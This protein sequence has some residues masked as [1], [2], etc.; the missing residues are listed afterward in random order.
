MS[1][2][3]E[4]GFKAG[5]LTVMAVRPGRT[6]GFIA[7]CRCECGNVIEIGAS[8]IE[9]NGKARGTCKASEHTTDR[10]T[11]HPLYGIWRGMISRCYN[12]GD[13]DHKNY[14][15]K[16]V[17]VCAEWFASPWPFFAYMPERPSMDHTIDRI[18]AAGD[19]K[20]GNVR[21]A[22]A[23]EQANNKRRTNWLPSNGEDVSPTVFWERHGCG[24]VEYKTFLYRLR[25]GWD[26]AAACSPST[27]PRK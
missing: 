7:T 6:R 20:P 16:G 18:D 12:H 27:I 21:W 3:P 13:K 23:T 5:H 1:F 22:T 15:A 19:Y 9:P 4:I 11:L 26:L 8:H 10:R 24:S 2:K 14:G 17:R 25:S